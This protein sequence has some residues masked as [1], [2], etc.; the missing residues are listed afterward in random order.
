MRRVATMVGVVTAARRVR[1]LA[2]AEWR[3]SR[4]MVVTVARGRESVH[5]EKASG[6]GEREEAKSSARA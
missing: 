6:D 1:T 3:A 5:E 4:R 2:R